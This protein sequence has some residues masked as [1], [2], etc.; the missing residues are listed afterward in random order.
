M[1]AAGYG[2]VTDPTGRALGMTTAY[3]KF[4]PFKDYLIPGIMLFTAIGILSTAIAIIA[5]QKLKYYPVL[6]AFQGCILTGWIIIQVIFVRDFNWLH[7]TFLVIGVLLIFLGQK[8]RERT[9]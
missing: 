9:L 8:M 7:L 3:L 5:I 4:S 2:F 1:L 6:V